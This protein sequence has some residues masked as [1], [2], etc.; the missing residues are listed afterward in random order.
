MANP[1]KITSN[2]VGRIRS[3][4]AFHIK[5]IITSHDGKCVVMAT[6]IKQL[7]CTNRI[8]VVPR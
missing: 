1:K 8:T 7:F 3:V 6:V 2:V 5:I 4:A